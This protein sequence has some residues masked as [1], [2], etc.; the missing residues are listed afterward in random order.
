LDKLVGLDYQCL[1]DI[2]IREQEVG[3]FTQQLSPEENELLYYWAVEGYTVQELS[4]ETGKP[5]GTLL[6]RLYRIRKK[7]EAFTSKTKLYRIRSQQ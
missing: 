4:D 5:K 7:A 6:S 3:E 2:I 1:E